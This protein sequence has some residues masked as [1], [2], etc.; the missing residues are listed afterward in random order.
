MGPLNA[1]KWEEFQFEGYDAIVVLPEKITKKQWLLK[2]EYFDAFPYLEV[3]MLKRGYLLAFITNKNRWGSREDLERKARFV[4]FIAEKYNLDSKVIPVGMS[5][6]GLYAIKFAGLFPEKVAVAYLDAPVVNILSCPC[7]L[8]K[9]K[10]PGIV[11]Q[12]VYNALGLNEITVLSYRD[13]PLDH[14]PSLIKNRI[15]VVLVYGDVDEVVGY[16][17]N[18][19]LVKEAY[20]KTDIPHLVICKPG[21]NHHPHGLEDP[22]KVIEFIEKNI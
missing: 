13:H 17:E 22:S 20:E 11:A 15:P 6:G 16:E 14:I 3:E 18:G 9:T 1:F 21:C 4:D 8:G 12:E 19:I 5:C 7:Y 2:T 10:Y